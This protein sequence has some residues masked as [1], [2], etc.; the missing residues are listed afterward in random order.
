MDPENQTL[1]LKDGRTFGYAEY[2][3]STGSPVF[4]FHG[5]GSSRL[6]K[7][8]SENILIRLD[9]RFI[10]VDRPG[11]GLSDYQPE[12][13]LMDWPKDIMQLADHLGLEKFYVSGHSAGG[14]VCF[15]LCS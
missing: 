7:P 8:A 6:E 1:I 13:R 12:R 3:V 11:H 10:S 5:S 9:I 4:H 14:A 2:G 15:S